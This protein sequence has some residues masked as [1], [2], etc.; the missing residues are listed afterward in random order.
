[1]DFAADH[2]IRL[3]KEYDNVIVLRSL[4]KGYS[5]AGLR[6]GYGL[7]QPALIEGLM[8]VKDSYN[9]DAIAI[10]AATAAILDQPYFLTHVELI[11]DQRQRLTENLRL[12]GFEAADSQTNFILVR[13]VNCSAKEIYEALIERNI[14]VRHFELPDMED[15]LRITVGT[16]EQNKILILALQEILS[17]EGMKT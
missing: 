16:P 13:C 5:L 14:Y 8:K 4:S 15:K 3:V 2:A 6:F 1:M 17:G 9:V 10:G 7:A 12:L 11:K